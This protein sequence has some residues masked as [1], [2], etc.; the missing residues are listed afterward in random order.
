MVL[1]PLEYPSILAPA[2]ASININSQIM[3]IY[4]SSLLPG[5]RHSSGLAS[6]ACLR[7]TEEETCAVRP[8]TCTAAAHQLFCQSCVSL[9]HRGRALCS[10][11]W[12]LY[13]YAASVDSLLQ[14]IQQLGLLLGQSAFLRAP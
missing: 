4:L 3:Q 1:P 7:S 10:Q 2:A 11:A 13:C 8:G 12:H 5:E 6:P 9:Q 14:Q